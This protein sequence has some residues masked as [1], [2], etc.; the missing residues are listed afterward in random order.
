[1]TQDNSKTMEI[2]SSKL[3]GLLDENKMKQA[4]LAEM[5]GVNE[6]T[7]GKWLL[8]KAMPRM[9]II[10]HLGIIFECPKSYL[11]ENEENRRTYYLNPET[12]KLAQEIYDN[13]EMKILFDA[14][15][16][17]K[18]DSIRE[19]QKFV[20]FQSSKERGELNE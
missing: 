20:E 16:K 19:I 7:V 9:N 12:A 6:S 1:M 13:P 11:L 5:L 4:E 18:P 8:K 2:F 3:K 10:E 15:K 14:T 17:L